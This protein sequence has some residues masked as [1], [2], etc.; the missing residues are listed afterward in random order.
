MTSKIDYDEIEFLKADQE[1]YDLNDKKLNI[2]G[3]E[4]SISDG[5]KTNLNEDI[6]H[7]YIIL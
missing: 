1:K 6:M 7:D 2:G 5:P 3:T 4:Y